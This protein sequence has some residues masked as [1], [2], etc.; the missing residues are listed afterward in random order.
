MCN[1]C[2]FLT[3]SELS[4]FNNVFEDIGSKIY[5]VGTYQGYKTGKV[6]L[7]QFLKLQ[8]LERLAKVVLELKCN[9]KVFK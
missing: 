6:E 5:L 1:L 7:S 3:A 8:S 4:F 9:I 2:V